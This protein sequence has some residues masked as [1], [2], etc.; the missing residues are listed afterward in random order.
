MKRS[1]AADVRTVCILAN[2]RQADL[3]GSKIIQNLQQEA[4]ATQTEINFVG[5]GGPW[6]KKEGF[7]ST[8]EIDI[9]QFADKTFTTYR[10]TK[11]SSEPLY[12][13]WNPL[14]LVNKHY[15]RQTNDIHEAVSTNPMSL[16]PCCFDS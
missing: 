7:D 16:L 1:F 6:M 10:K 11:T 4:K 8:V 12:M 13:R 3:I 15:T 2:S 5:Y 14:N 9:D